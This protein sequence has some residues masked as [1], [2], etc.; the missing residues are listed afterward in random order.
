[1]QF[2]IQKSVLQEAI[3][4]V[5]KAITGKSTMPILQGI[6]IK[7][8]HNQLLL[9][10]SDKDLTI[11]TTIECDIQ[12]SGELVVDSRL[13]GDLI[14]KLPNDVIEV[15]TN[16]NSTLS[17]KCLKSNATLVY[18]EAT[19]YPAVP[20]IEEDKVLTLPQNLLKNMIKSTIFAISHDETKPILT[21][22]L[23]DAKDNK[24]NLVATDRYRVS[25][26]TE[27]INSSVEVHN[28]IPGKTLGEVSKLLSD[29]EEETEI[30]FTQNHILFRL[31]NTRVISRLLEGEFIKYSS[32]IPKEY[33]L[34][35][36]VDKSELLSCIDRASLMGKEGK[37]NLVKL[38]IQN[39]TMVITSNSQLGMARE[40][41]PIILQ[42]DELKISFNSKYLMDNLKVMDSD[43]VEMEFSTNVNPCVIKNKDN[44]NC[45]CLLLPV[46]T[47]D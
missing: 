7:T 13:F 29:G 34:K 28:V 21:G 16:E 35:V 22:V 37:T 31:G 10:G 8:R 3:A 25:I 17:I 42:G 18:M 43:E 26:R 47:V 44:N 11:V 27:G 5:Q 12:S 14:R 41:L 32:I 6:Y 33:L 19:D 2:K 1:M 9:M 4:T 40:E 20:E 24:L 36:I 30:L 38:N 15:S 39:E 46:R 45:T 23:F